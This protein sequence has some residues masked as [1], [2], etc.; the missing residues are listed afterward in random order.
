MTL[1]FSSLWHFP[2]QTTK[3]IQRLTFANEHVSK[4]F[5]LSTMAMEINSEKGFAKYSKL[6]EES[7]NNQRNEKIAGTVSNNYPANAKINNSG[8]D[9]KE[10]IIGNQSKIRSKTLI[11]LSLSILVIV[12]GLIAGLF[13]MDLKSKNLVKDLEFQQ[14]IAQNFKAQNQNLMH[15]LGNMTNIL[16][17]TDTKIV[18]LENDKSKLSNQVFQLQERNGVLENDII[19][20]KNNGSELQLE[21]VSCSICRKLPNFEIGV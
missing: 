21:I 4:H 17:S 2:F 20:F 7:M 15:V 11:G 18:K 12:S 14:Q 9:F 19:D 6:A 1:R 8:L 16:N 10:K 3:L 5:L 13:I